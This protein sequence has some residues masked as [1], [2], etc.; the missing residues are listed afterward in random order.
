[1]L[2]LATKDKE[3]QSC[4]F[5]AS[6]G[7]WRNAYRKNQSLAQIRHS[8]EN[9][10]VLVDCRQHTSYLHKGSIVAGEVQK[11]WLSSLAMLLINPGAQVPTHTY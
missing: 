11:G 7:F 6:M 10:Q 2:L 1:M 5:F 4:L 9:R 8:S 3:K